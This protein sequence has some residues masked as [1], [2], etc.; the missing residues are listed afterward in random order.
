[1]EVRARMVKRVEDFCYNMLENVFYA[2]DTA[3]IV[4]EEILKHNSYD[5]GT[6]V[7]KIEDPAQW[8][9]QKISEKAKAI[10][11]HKGPEGDFD[12]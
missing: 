7:G 12:D 3:P 8:T 9:P 10:Q 4:I 2:S 5:P 6:K 1:M 11:S